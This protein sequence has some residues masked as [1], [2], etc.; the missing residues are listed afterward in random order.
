MTLERSVV[1]PG[2]LVEYRSFGELLGGLSDEQWQS[3][4]RCAGWSVADVAGHVVGQLSDV[5]A[6]RL[7]G[8]GTPEATARQ[9][10]E[11]RGRTADDLAQ[12]LDA[13]TQ[14]AADLI[15]SF[16]DDAYNA[17]GPQGN[18]QTLGY[19]IESLWFDTFLHADDIR[20]AFGGA[21]TST[22]AHA[23]SVSHIAQVLTHQGWHPATIRLNGLDE[24]LVGNGS[25]DRVIDGDPMEFI[26][27]STGR[28]DPGPLGL[29]PTVNIYR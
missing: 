8:L 28:A 24:F 1:V 9:V 21:T 4:S 10:E 16:D 19:G 27:V 6:F 14:T 23:P 11:R 7:E 5:T 22:D 17:E 13:T 18:G 3:P 12:E 15:G 20:V 25:E 2:V 26:L 29:D